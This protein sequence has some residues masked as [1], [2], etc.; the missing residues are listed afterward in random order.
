M[1]I[2]KYFWDILTR[3]NKNA[4]DLMCYH[5]FEISRVIYG[6]NMPLK[7]ASDMELANARSS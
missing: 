4:M 2:D 7:R 6:I 3:L 1:V 5:Y